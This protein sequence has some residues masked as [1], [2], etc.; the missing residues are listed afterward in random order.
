MQRINF[1]WYRT[2]DATAGNNRSSIPTDRQTNEG[3]EA[4]PFGDF[5]RRWR[6]GIQPRQQ[7]FLFRISPHRIIRPLLSYAVCICRRQPSPELV[8]VHRLPFLDSIDIDSHSHRSTRPRKTHSTAKL[9][10][11]VTHWSSWWD[12]QRTWTL[13]MIN[14]F[15]GRH[16][17]RVACSIKLSSHWTKST[18]RCRRSSPSLCFSGGN[19]LSLH[20]YTWMRALAAA[21]I[22][23]MPISSRIRI[24]ERTVQLL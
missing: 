24:I 6:P 22:S 11:M 14:S 23:G 15:I 2:A 16:P 10:R 8:P 13:F 19:V 3:V 4:S 7:P 21:T 1:C 5:R 18:F 9:F 12:F 17:L 20:S